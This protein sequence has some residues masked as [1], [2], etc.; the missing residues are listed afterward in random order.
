L[1][2][3]KKII[4]RLL[5]IT[6]YYLIQIVHFYDS[7]VPEAVTLKKSHGNTRFN[8]TGSGIQ[9]YDSVKWY[10]VGIFWPDPI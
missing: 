7:I 8:H 10:P 4:D 9:R 5:R 1:A 2:L 6:M 3:K